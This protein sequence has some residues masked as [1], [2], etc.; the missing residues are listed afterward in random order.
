MEDNSFWGSGW[1]FPPTFQVGKHQLVMTSRE[2]NINECI[3]IILQTRQRERNLF[4]NFGSGLQ[5]FVFRGETESL[6]GEIEAV[7]TQ[8][9]RDYEPRIQVETVHVELIDSLVKT[10]N[11]H[12]DYRIRTTN[13]RHNH[14]FPFSLK[15]G[16]NL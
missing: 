8:T 15:E 12:I 10:L 7:V 16:T 6:I 14:V 4:P 2:E 5:Q 1:S 13:T 9:L 3:N 11:I